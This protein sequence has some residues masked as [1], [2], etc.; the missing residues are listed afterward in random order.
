MGHHR[1]LRPSAGGPPHRTSRR[2][3]GPAEQA[4]GGTERRPPRRTARRQGP[5][6]GDRARGDVATAAGDRARVRRVAAVPAAGAHHH[7]CRRGVRR[8]GFRRCGVRPGALPGAAAP[9]VGVARRSPGCAPSCRR[10]CAPRC[11]RIRERPALLRRWLELPEGR[12]D[13]DGW[14]G[15]ARQREPDPVGRAR[16][17][18]TSRDWTS[19]WA[20]CQTVARR[21]EPCNCGATLCSYLE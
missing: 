3:P 20:S 11:C 18:V 4:P 15:V 9:A 13:R 5:R 21:D 17:A 14:R 10:P 6:R 16:R 12:D 2:H 8:A 1:R 19:N 7:R